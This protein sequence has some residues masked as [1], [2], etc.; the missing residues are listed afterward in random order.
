MIPGCIS[1]IDVAHQELVVKAC[2][3]FAGWSINYVSKDGVSAL[4]RQS[5]EP[6]DRQL[7]DAD[8]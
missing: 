7:L 3:S 5:D 6:P 4:R 1:T 8:R 2:L